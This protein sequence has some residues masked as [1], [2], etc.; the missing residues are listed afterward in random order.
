MQVRTPNPTS[1]KINA[2]VCCRC[3]ALAGADPFII[4][5]E[6]VDPS[7]V[8]CHVAEKM[9]IRSDFAVG[10]EVPTWCEYILEHLMAD[11]DCKPVEK[12]KKELPEQISE[13]LWW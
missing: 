4:D 2:G 10:E 9:G 11:E 13:D 1:A 7:A 6:G 8:I 12:E 3:E 5:I